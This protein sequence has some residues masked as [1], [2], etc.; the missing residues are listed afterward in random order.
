MYKTLAHPMEVKTPRKWLWAVI[1]SVTLSI[2]FGALSIGLLIGAYGMDLPALSKNSGNLKQK[3]ELMQKENLFQE[4]LGKLDINPV[5]TINY[6][7]EEKSIC[8][9]DHCR[10][11]LEV[12]YG[13][14]KPIR[15]KVTEIS[16]EF[17][18]KGWTFRKITKAKDVTELEQ[19]FEE[20]KSILIYADFTKDIF[21]ARI[22]F[23]KPYPNGCNVVPKLCE[24]ANM[25]TYPYA[26]SIIYKAI[27]N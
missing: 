16:E 22:I 24:Y 10:R 23:A 1:I 7:D 3:Q 5:M 26:I 27:V 19:Q 18:A 8:G 6:E 15:E 14:D 4:E 25:N 17:A 11:S 2:I 13:G 9:P 20:K 21:S 12:I